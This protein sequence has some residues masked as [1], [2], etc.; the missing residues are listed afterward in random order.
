MHQDKIF[1]CN[2][3]KQDDEYDLHFRIGFKKKEQKS[4]WR[5]KVL[6]HRDLVVQRIEERINSEVQQKNAEFAKQKKLDDEFILKNAK[7][8]NLH[9][10]DETASHLKT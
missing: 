8:S 3:D 1:L 2:E 5:D 10:E 4:E 9:R 6:S 7:Q